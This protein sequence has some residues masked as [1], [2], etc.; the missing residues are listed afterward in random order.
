MS[1][2]TEKRKLLIASAQAVQLLQQACGQRSANTVARRTPSRAP[3]IARGGMFL[4]GNN[5]QRAKFA[6]VAT[7]KPDTCG[8]VGDGTV[9]ESQRTSGD[10]LGSVL[11]SAP[12]F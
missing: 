5:H 9:T 10:P 2:T 1:L 4:L 8:S 7:D 11:G 12:F 3:K 6:S